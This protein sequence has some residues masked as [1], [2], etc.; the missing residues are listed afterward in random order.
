MSI[1]RE[2][3]DYHNLRSWVLMADEG[4]LWMLHPPHLLLGVGLLSILSEEREGG[5]YQVLLPLRLII[6]EDRCLVHHLCRQVPNMLEDLPFLRLLLLHQQLRQDQTQRT[7][8][9]SM[10]LEKL[11]SRHPSDRLVRNQPRSLVISSRIN[12]SK[13]TPFRTLRVV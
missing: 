7:F 5:R 10:P 4:D 11:Q 2:K 9:Y 8:I 12:C 6:D 13:S 1:Y 3:G